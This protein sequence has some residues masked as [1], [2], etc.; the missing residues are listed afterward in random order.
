MTTNELRIT[1]DR[2]VGP[3]TSRRRAAWA[4]SLASVVFA[5]SPA[6]A[7][8]MQYGGPGQNF[9]VED[10]GIAAKWPDDGPRKTWVRK[11]GEGYSAI[12]ADA[13]RLYTMYRAGE[14]EVVVCLD[15]ADGKTVWEYAYKSSPVEGHLD[16][17]GRGPN[18]TPLLADSR[19]YTIGIAG[20]MHCL[21]LR[22]GHVLWSHDFVKEFG[23]WMPEFGYSQSPIA[24]RDTVIALVGGKDHSI[25]AFDK[26]GGHVVWKNLRFV[27]SYS[28]PRILKI[29]GE[30]QLVTFM[31]QELI[32]TDPT[33]GELKWRYPIENQYKQNIT[34]PIPLDDDLLVVSQYQIGARGL[35][36]TK[37]ESFSV[38]ELWSQRKVQFFYASSVRIGDYVYGS[39]ASRAAP[40]IYAVN[41]RSGDIAWRERGFAP[42]YFVGVGD[43]VIIL[44][45]DGYLALATVDPK[46]LNV[47]SK[48]Q[49][50]DPPARTAPTIAGHMLYARDQTHIMGLDL[51]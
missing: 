20:D 41:M 47:H 1:S 22:D 29:H 32:G 40:I 26:A 28:T 12:L 5:I 15:A 46:G 38:K 34:M 27:N 50:L 18:A 16:E 49:M 2:K 25:I 37:G 6:H 3:V 39:S 31:G 51:R 36:I 21:D 24:Y 7:Q 23:A 14:N 33:S 42:A 44:D 10:V 43:R 30:D 8:W 17:Y 9:H 45:E 19:L 48:V 35:R 11:L 13:G 4:A